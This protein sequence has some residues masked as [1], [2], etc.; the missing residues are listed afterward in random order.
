VSSLHDSAGVPWDGR[1]FSQNNFANDSGETP[2]TL[3]RGLAEFESGGVAALAEHLAGLRVLV[4]L[5]A[6]K[7]GSEI[8]PH[9]LEVDSQ[10]DMAIVAIATPDQQSAVPV[11]GSVADLAAWRSDARPVPIELARAA[12]GAIAEGHRRLV[13]N[14][15]GQAIGLRYPLLKALAT[16]GSWLSPEQSPRVAE[17]V[18]A[19]TAQDPS[20]QSWSLAAN[21]PIG[22]L[23]KPELMIELTLRPGLGPEQL[24][25]TLRRLA[26]ALQQ[27]D[28]PDLVDSFGF[29]LLVAR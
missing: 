7:V 20:I 10:A 19:A 9:G 13:L 17:L 21:D 8:G 5:L 29:R 4:P 27:G 26:E 14:P 6:E 25:Q 18:A 11:F 2:E 28:W 23:Q 24:D 15:A 22:T 16:G 3:A 1:S 12:L